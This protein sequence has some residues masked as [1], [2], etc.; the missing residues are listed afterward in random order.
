MSL[1]SKCTIEL[2]NNEPMHQLNKLKPFNKDKTVSKLAKYAIVVCR[3]LD[4]NKRRNFGIFAT[5][6]EKEKKVQTTKH[7]SKL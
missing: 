6:N 7:Y 4:M 1:N 2:S 3:S 5:S